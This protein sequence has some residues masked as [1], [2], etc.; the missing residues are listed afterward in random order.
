MKTDDFSQQKQWAFDHIEAFLAGE[1]SPDDTARFHRLRD[2]FPELEREI[3]FA[4]LIDVTLTQLPSPE[5][6]AKVTDA[7]LAEVQNETELKKASGDPL[8]KRSPVFSSWRPA[9]V[10]AAVVGFMLVG[11]FNKPAPYEEPFVEYTEHDIARAEIEAKLALA[12]LSKI[13]K[14]TGFFVRDDIIAKNVVAP[15]RRAAQTPFSQ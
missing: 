5:C 3:E 10:A 2:H 14:K 1:L 12:Y 4:K 9:L 7:A 6:P 13:S 11:L 8:L 15:I